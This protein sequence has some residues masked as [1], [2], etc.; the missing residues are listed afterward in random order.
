M[1][2]KVLAAAF[3]LAF[4]AGILFAA[5]PNTVKPIE[6]QKEILSYTVTM[7][8][9]NTHYYHIVFRCEGIKE[10]TVEFKMPAWSP[11]YYRIL[12]FARN[13][14]KFEAEDGTGKAAAWEKAGDNSWQVRKGQ[15]SIVTISYDV[16]AKGRGVAESNLDE[17]KGYISPTSV[18]MYISGQMEQP[19]NV[20]VKP[21][22]NFKTISTGLD[23]VEGKE[24]TFRA[25][26]FDTLYDS[27]IYVDNQQVTSFEYQGIPY[28]IAVGGEKEIDMEKVAS[29]LKPM[30]EAAVGI[31]GEAPYKHYTFI[32]MG[33]GMGGLEHQNSMA[34]FTRIPNLDKPKETGGFLSFMAHEF[35]HLYNV[36]AIRPIALGPF[37]YDKGSVTDMLWFSEGGTVYYEYLILSRAGFMGRDEILGTMGRCIE[38]YES[39]PGHLVQSVAQSSSET[40][41]QPFFGGKDTISYYDKGAALAMLLDLKIR[42]ET[43]N[44]KSLDDVMK[45]LYQKY[46]K[47]LKRGFTDEEFQRVCEETAGTTLSEFF[48]YVTTPKEVDYQKYLGYAGLEMKIPKE[49][50]EKGGYEIKPIANPDA[51]QSEILNSWLKV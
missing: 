44:K 43:K 18:F 19:V 5:E 41:T 49:K 17:K 9:P 2:K 15:S 27:P 10:E 13:V 24:N 8:E 50:T 22:K 40:W 34:V 4:L 46:Y 25:A 51:L 39:S 32:I 31:V 26:N 1:R 33:A 42:H 20:T 30:V 12:N 23:A 14:S 36:K 6:Q 38:K 28:Q 21:Y 47:G 16:N 29:T 45:T 11:G 7:D 48:E 35:F 37:D 3:C